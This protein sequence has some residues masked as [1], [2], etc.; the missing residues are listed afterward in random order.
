MILLT[1]QK[2]LSLRKVFTKSGNVYTYIHAYTIYRHIHI[3]ISANVVI[4]EL[5]NYAI[6]SQIS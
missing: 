2:I 3:C 6:K 4:L 5:V 1:N